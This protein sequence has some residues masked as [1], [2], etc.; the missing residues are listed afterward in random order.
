MCEDIAKGKFPSPFKRKIFIIFSEIRAA[1]INDKIF[2]S[3]HAPFSALE[4]SRRRRAEHPPPESGD[5]SL[6][7]R[8]RRTSGTPK[9]R[10]EK[11]A[12]V[13]RSIFILEFIYI[14]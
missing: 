14:V 13:D 11:Y 6:Y 4:C 12:F 1:F 8:F 9:K 5:I 10:N 7:A 3:S 2:F